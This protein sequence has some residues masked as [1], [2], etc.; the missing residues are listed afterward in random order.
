MEQKEISDLDFIK[1]DFEQ[2]RARHLLFKSRLR[3]ILYGIEVDEVPVLSHYECT[4]GKWI[5]NHALKIYGH[6]PEMVELEKVHADIHISARELIALY[7]EGK[8]EEARKGQ[9]EMEGI[10]D[11]LVKLLALLEK[12]LLADPIPSPVVDEEKD[13]VSINL[14]ELYELQ[15]INYQ[16]DLRMKEQSTELIKA[17][18]RFDLVAKATQ[19]AVWDWD[20]QNQTVW[21]N[22]SFTEL[23]GF[24]KDEIEPGPESWYN[25]IH[26]DDQEWVVNSIHDVID[27]GGNKW[28]AEYRF[29]RKD[30]SYAFVFDRA[31]ALHDD[32]GKPYRMVG[33]MQDITE[34]KTSKEALHQAQLQLHAALSA[35]LVS[36]FFWDIQKDMFYADANLARTFAVSPEEAAKGLPLHVLVNAIHDDDKDRVMTLVNRAIE[37]GE[38][39]EA[40]YRVINSEGKERWVIARGRVNYDEAGKPLNFPGTLVD[41]TERKSTEEA[42]RRSEEQFRVFGNS[43]QNLAWIA[44]GDG[45]I[46]W[47][48]D[49]WYEYTGTTLEEMQGWGWEKV[50]HPDH[51]DRVLAFVKE[52]WKRDEPWEL[53]FPLRS[54]T[55]S[56]RWFLTRAVPVKNAEGKIYNW[57]GTN[58]DIHDKMELEQELERRVEERTRALQES[59]QKLERS[60]EELEQFAYVTSHDLQEP[61]RKIQVFTN[62]LTERCSQGISD[63]ARKYIG[64][65]SDSARRM[66]GQI[67]DLLQFSRLSQKTIQYE[68]LHLH[69]VVQD[70]L[71][72]L[73]VLIAQKKARILVGDLPAVQ[74]V[75]LQVNQLFYNL[76][77]NALKF[78]KPDE[79]PVIEITSEPAAP[80][81]YK[82]FPDLEAGVAYTHIT[83]KDNGIGF[84]QDYGEKIFTIFQRLNDRSQYDGFGIGLAICKKVVA[85]HKGIIYAESTP[86]VGSSFHIV[87]PTA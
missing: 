14:K 20:L 64:K 86:G 41:I 40:D 44:D 83:V 29:R 13:A 49:R 35:G 62:I 42:L 7:K 9:L 60:N 2:A 78:S 84:K 30:G 52:A 68:K 12:K 46:F 51:I 39:Y 8:V 31:Y 15:K 3:S 43:I 26:P 27:H 5:Y 80:E 54:H 69:D 32:E 18:D 66:A 70:V 21:W 73:E 25:R 59:N 22:D 58:T 23:F 61:L 38:D 76:V 10:A 34:E 82:S 36:T 55:G 57:I 74:A 4:L 16:L 19:D 85:N 47:Y 37:T 67:K 53:V 81:M 56:Y 87:L 1:L 6:L 17:K 28:S 79:S 11:R 72:D 71:K 63:D 48:N 75:S 24:S 65:I 77:N 45:W 50:H 33:S